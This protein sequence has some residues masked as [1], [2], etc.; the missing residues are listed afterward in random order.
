MDALLLE[1]HHPQQSAYRRN[2]TT[3][4]FRDADGFP[5]DSDNEYNIVVAARAQ[6]HSRVRR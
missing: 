4:E 5:V 3:I 2:S 1:A 6:R